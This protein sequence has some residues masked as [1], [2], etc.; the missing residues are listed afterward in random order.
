MENKYAQLFSRVKAAFVDSVVL[1]IL[2]YSATWIFNMVEDVPNYVRTSIFILLFL[3]YEPFL[4]SFF[5][6]TV[7]H[8]FNDIVVKR[9]NNEEKN[10]MLLKA[11]VR[12]IFKLL[13]GWISLLTVKNNE[14]QKAIHDYI[15]GSVVLKYGK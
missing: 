13:L 4:I 2:M 6:T 14:K 9:E 3:L 12:F 10:V 5:G 8:F 15:G 1:V 7:G 11:I